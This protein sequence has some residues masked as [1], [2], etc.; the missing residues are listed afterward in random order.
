MR[1][2]LGVTLFLMIFIMF[3]NFSNFVSSYFMVF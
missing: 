2:Q 1:H 3:V